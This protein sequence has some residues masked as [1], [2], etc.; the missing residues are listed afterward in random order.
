MLFAFSQLSLSWASGSHSAIGDHAFTI[1]K[2][3]NRPCYKWY[4]T[5]NEDY[6]GKL[7]K[8]FWDPDI[9]E[10]SSG[11]HYYIWPG[12]GT[13]NTGQ[14]YPMAER[15][16]KNYSARTRMEEHYQM[17]LDYYKEGNMKKA[18]QNIGRAVHYLG[19]IG[20]P[21][22]A[23]GIQYPS[24]P[25]ATNYHH[26][27][28]SYASKVMKKDENTYAHATTAADVYG[29]LKAPWGVELNNV[30]ETSARQG[31]NILTKDEATWDKAITVAGPLSERYVAVLLDQFYQ[32]TH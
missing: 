6:M 11:T 31:P 30:C 28:E 9:V 5:D 26:L 2:N 22:H 25:F 3:D 29:K 18:F 17:A 21:P 14:Y 4:R 24:N 20:C 1:L 10:F 27:F 7:E 8:G 12:E 13:V 23:A 15:H 19:D 16:G 32:D